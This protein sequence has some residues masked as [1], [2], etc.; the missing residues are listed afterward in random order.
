MAVTNS[1]PGQTSLYEFGETLFL[2]IINAQPIL[3]TEQ[4]IRSHLR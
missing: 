2:A 3:G 4:I 1:K